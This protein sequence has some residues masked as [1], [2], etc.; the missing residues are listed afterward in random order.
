MKKIGKFIY[1]KST[2]PSKKLMVHVNGKTI[3]FG[4][5]KMQHFKDKTGIWKDKD[6]LDKDRR[7]R[8]RKRASKITN[9]KGELTYKDINSA[10]YHSYNIFW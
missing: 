1:E 5:S 4:D 8:Y 3:H 9:K 10:N 7:E 2:R 6:H